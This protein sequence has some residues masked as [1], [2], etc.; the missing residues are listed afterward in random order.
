MS[1]YNVFNVF[2]NE[3]EIF[4]VEAMISDQYKMP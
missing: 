1:I 2:I 3:T 4:K